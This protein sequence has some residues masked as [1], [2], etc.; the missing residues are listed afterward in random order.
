VQLKLKAPWRDGTTHRVMSPLEFIQRLAALEFI[1]RLAALE[2][3]QRLAA[4][5]FIQRLAALVPQERQPPARA[6]QP[7]DC[8]ANR[9]QCRPSGVLRP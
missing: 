2:F 7:A 6:T 1:Q 9:A 5:E 3:I 8:E 4:L